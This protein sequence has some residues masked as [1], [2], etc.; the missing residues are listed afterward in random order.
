MECSTWNGF[1]VFSA[2]I[3]KELPG[4]YL[5]E[6]LSTGRRYVGISQNIAQR[7]RAHL[8]SQ[9]RDRRSKLFIE[10]RAQG[11]SA[12]RAVPL[13][14]SLNGTRGLAKIESELIRDLDCIERGYNVAAASRGAGPYGPAHAAL[15]SAALS[16][17]DVRQKKAAGEAIN[18]KKRGAAIRAAH[19]SPETKARLRARRRGTITDEMRK[20][21]SARMTR[22][23]NTRR[24]KARVSAQ[25]NALYSDPKFKAMHLRRVRAANKDPSRN[26]R[27]AASRIGGRWI[28]DGTSRSFLGPQKPIPEGWRIG[29]PDKPIKY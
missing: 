17:P 13:F 18:A 6:H 2:N 19:S 3:P 27:I 11:A 15:V 7:L 9:S 8:R 24:A 10:L 29:Q 1:S 26:R 5:I 4:I 14:Y 23:Q 20:A 16:R 28:T 12:F 22:S 25:M 21:M